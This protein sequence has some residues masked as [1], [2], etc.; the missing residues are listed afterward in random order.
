MIILWPGVL[1]A[2]DN[3]LWVEVADSKSL[4][5][6]IEKLYYNKKLLSTMKSNNRELGFRYGIDEHI[7]RL[8]AIY[9]DVSSIKQREENG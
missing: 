4:E 1:V 7:K 9:A 2:S 8:C 6:A 3:V 5:E